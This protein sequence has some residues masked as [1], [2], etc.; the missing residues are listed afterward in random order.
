MKKLLITALVL[1]AGAGLLYAE[2]NKGKAKNGKNGQCPLAQESLE[3]CKERVAEELEAEGVRGMFTTEGGTTDVYYA[4][5]EEQC[6]VPYHDECEL[7]KHLE[8]VL[9]PEQKE[10]QE[11]GVGALGTPTQELEAI[12]D[13]D[14]TMTY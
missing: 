5:V 12:E 13:V 1:S 2:L 10:E 7:E 11:K 14:A 8:K 3:R 6:Y 4:Q 9:A